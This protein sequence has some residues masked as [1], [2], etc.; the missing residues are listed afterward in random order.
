M[1]TRQATRR[2]CIPGGSEDC[3]SGFDLPGDLNDKAIA[4]LGW[5][6]LLFSATILLVHWARASSTAA[7]GHAST[8]N[9]ADMGILAGAMLG[10]VVCALAWSRRIPQRLML[11]AGLLFQAAAAFCIALVEFRI[12]L[13]AT[14]PIVGVSGIALWITF[15]VLVVPTTSGKALLG[16]LASALTG[17]LALLVYAAVEGVPLP[18]RGRMLS[19]FLPDLLAA[20]WSLLLARYVYGMGKALGK[21][22]P[23]VTTNW[24]SRSAVGVWEKCGGPGTKCSPVRRRSS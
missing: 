21:A 20:A 11:D 17:P 18:D 8:A 19:M 23:W 2:F 9:I 10:V 14:D 6:A 1:N 22:R 24:R 3:S 5:V 15:F 16:A 7:F 4:R 12:R 13:H